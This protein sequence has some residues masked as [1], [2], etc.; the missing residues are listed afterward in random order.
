MQPRPLTRSAG[1]TLIELMVVVVI[2]TILLSIAIPSYMSQIRQSRRVDAKTAVLDLAGREE[3]Y[4]STSG[5]Q[6]SATPADLGYSVAWPAPVAPNNYYNVTVCTSAS[7]GAGC[8]GDQN[9]NVPAAPWYYIL[10]TP[11]AGSSQTAD[12]SCQVFGVDSTGYQWSLDNN[13]NVTTTTC[14]PN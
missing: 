9:P 10:A 3:S 13:G 6:Y 11:A 4:F 12:N 1:F 5:S 2:A 8:A 14:W 7:A